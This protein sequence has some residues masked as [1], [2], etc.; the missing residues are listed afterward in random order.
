MKPFLALAM[1]ALVLLFPLFVSAHGD[2]SHVLGTVT[3][4]APDHIVVKTPKG[5]S[6]TL[7]LNANT[8]VQRDGITTKD[9]RPEVGNRLVAEGKKEGDTLFATEINFSSSTSK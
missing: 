2:A 4:T 3:K 8:I 9:A 1:I 6:V 5:T 7:V